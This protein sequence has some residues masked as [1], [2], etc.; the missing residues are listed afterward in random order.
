[1][2]DDG[3]DRARL[4]DRL[5]SLRSSW[6]GLFAAHLGRRLL[7]PRPVYLA[8]DRVLIRTL[9]GHKLIVDTRD[10]S[11]APSLLLNGTWEPGTSRAVV[12]ALRPGMR[13][14]EVGANLGWYSILIAS[15]VGP[16]G[17]LEAFEANP[18]V[19]ELLRTNLN[20][21][22]LLG[23][24]RVHPV[25]VTDH[26]G[27]ITLHVPVRH[28]G[29]PSTLDVVARHLEQLGDPAEALSVPAVR[30]DDVLKDGPP[31]DFLKMDIE[32]GEPF[33]LDGMGELIARSPGLRMVLEFAPSFLTVAGRD[34]RE[35]LEGLRS[36]G[37][38]LWRIER[39]GGLRRISVDEALGRELCDLFLARS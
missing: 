9:F 22:G 11:L 29:A 12:R 30:L 31:I 33:A 18:S 35:Y 36:K 25:A 26:A 13:A 14:V 37:F 32:G 34:P 17:F 27:T 3:A 1:M 20:V 39:M 24:V 6:L 16:T 19:L 23:S 4:G 15:A 10:V 8:N 21:N 7:Q 28:Q 2:R 38:A 5:R